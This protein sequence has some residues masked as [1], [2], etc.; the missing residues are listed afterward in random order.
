MT[1]HTS[2]E[3]LFSGLLL[4][5]VGGGIDYRYLAILSGLFQGGFF[6]PLDLLS[7]GSLDSPFAGRIP[8]GVLSGT[9]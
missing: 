6:M 8:E 1:G 2:D 4:A 5:V 3:G 9:V 7:G